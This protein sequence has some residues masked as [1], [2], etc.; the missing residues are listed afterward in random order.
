MGSFEFEVSV[1][2]WVHSVSMKPRCGAFD[3]DTLVTRFI[4]G[5]RRARLACE[6]S[7][8]GLVRVVLEARCIRAAL[9]THAWYG[10]FASRVAV[11]S[12]ITRDSRASVVEQTPHCTVLC[13]RYVHGRSYGDRAHGPV[14]APRARYGA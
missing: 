13:K 4:P 5:A 2:W 11:S 1:A 14:C 10:S 7:R 6:A 8:A 9:G 12:F 3:L